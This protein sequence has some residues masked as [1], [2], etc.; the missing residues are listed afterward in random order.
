MPV[1][2]PPNALN[3]VEVKEGTGAAAKIGDTITVHYVGIVCSTG[4]QFDASWDRAEPAVFPLTE[5]GLIQGWT[6]GIPG[7]KVGGR[8]QLEVPSDLAYGAQG[9][10][11]EIGPDEALIFV[12]DLVAIDPG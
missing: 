2:P 4:Q 8:R 10:P 3:I 7:M 12:F 1:G 11:P 9:R 5:G 6:D